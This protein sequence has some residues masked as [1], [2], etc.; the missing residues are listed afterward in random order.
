MALINRGE[1]VF[2]VDD[3]NCHI[4]L[5]RDFQD[6]R[7]GSHALNFRVFRINRKNFTGKAVLNEPLHDVGTD[8]VL[9]I[10]CTDDS[11]AAR[12]HD[13]IQI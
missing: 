6:G 11:Q 8:G 5:F 12:A 3:D 9:F 2:S 10:G 1:Y 4:D 13:F 7:V